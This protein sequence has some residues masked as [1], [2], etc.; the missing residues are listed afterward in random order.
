MDIK[1]IQIRIISIL[2]VFVLFSSTIAVSKTDPTPLAQ[3]SELKEWTL[4]FYCCADLDEA[5]E[6]ANESL[7]QI[8][9]MFMK[10]PT[11]SKLKINIVVLI[12]AATVI[13]GYYSPSKLQIINKFSLIEEY[14]ELNLGNYTVLRD[15]IIKCK[16]DFP[17]NKY[18]L[19]GFGH[20]GAWR[21]AFPDSYTN[22]S[23]K[24]EDIITMEE[25]HKALNES[26]G[27]DILFLSNCIMGCLESAYELRNC[28]DVYISSQEVVS[29]HLIPI[30][31]W[32]NILKVLKKNPYSSSYDIADKI[33]N[34]F[35]FIFRYRWS[36]MNF[37]V[38]LVNFLSSGNLSRLKWPRAFTMSAIRSDKIN[39]LCLSLDNLSKLLIGNQSKYE[40]FVTN[41]RM[42]SEDF[43]HELLTISKPIEGFQ[44]DLYH[45][46][47]LLSKD[48]FDDVE[49]TLYNAAEDV[50]NCM[51]NAV[52][53]EWHQKDHPN[54]NGLSLFYPT[55][56]I[57]DNPAPYTN[58]NYDT[59]V[60]CTLEFTKDYTWDEFLEIYL[61]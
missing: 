15:F 58:Y 52:I 8:Q 59:Y 54:A 42:E 9:K 32:Y 44:I 22:D 20:G 25:I 49:L 5:N 41:V 23:E 2:L 16:N 45:F 7:L 30:S 61:N 19:F 24:H 35:K 48:A 31:S 13:Y 1:I 47:D 56:K 43:P 6:E 11:L 53:N 51:N 33:I 36:P 29:N 28:T 39:N 12:D 3:K 34:R 27:T 17:A 21:G 26:G 60:N 18:F 14:E 40:S 50:K 10:I 46:I 37:I 55:C 38:P 57:P 4:M